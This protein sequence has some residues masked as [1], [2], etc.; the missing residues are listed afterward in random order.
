MRICGISDIHGNL[1]KDIPKCDVL[2]ICGDI[3]PLDIQRQMDDSIKWFQNE[4]ANWVKDLPCKKVI[5]VPG[6]HDFYLENKLKEWKGFV[7]DYEIYTDGKVRFLADELFNYEGVSFYGTPWINPILFG[8]WAFEYST[9]EIE[10]N[11]FEKIPK[12]DILLTHDNPNHN[13]SLGHY[14]FGKY[15]HHLFGHWHDGTSYKHLGQHNCSILDD[16]YNLKKDLNIVTVDIMKKEDNAIKIEFIEYLKLII[17]DYFRLN[18]DKP[19]T[20]EELNTFFD[21]QKE[22]IESSEEDENE[23]DRNIN[24]EFLYKEY[25]EEVSDD[26]NPSDEELKEAA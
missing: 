5:A 19:L 7:E 2:C 22:F 26:E 8:K 21:M 25:N 16:Y 11:P 10:D 20:L 23:W 4:F 17:R 15:K 1:I 24:T 14:C 9:N 6:N 13:H 12:C 18:G 3:V